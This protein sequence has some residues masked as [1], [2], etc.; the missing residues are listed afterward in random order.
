MLLQWAV[1]GPATAY[2]GKVVFSIQFYKTSTYTIE[3]EDGTSLTK[4]RYDYVLNTLPAL[5][6]VYETMQIESFSENYIFE[7][8]EAM[9]LFE[10]IQSVRK[11]NKMY[12]I[13][14]S[15]YDPLE[16]LF[17]ENDNPEQTINKN[18]EIY[19]NITS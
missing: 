18:S 13:D 19:S 4:Y 8:S 10:E 9:R 1:E 17:Q 5:T 12:W 7:A 6:K 2:E 11:Q 14:L 16:P 3:T 15:K